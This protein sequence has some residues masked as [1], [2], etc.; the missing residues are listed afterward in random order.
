MDNQETWFKGCLSVSSEF[1]CGF[2]CGPAAALC[3]RGEVNLVVEF[4]F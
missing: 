3:L 4:H 1:I 2:G